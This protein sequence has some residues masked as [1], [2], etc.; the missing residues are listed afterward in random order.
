MSKK[1]AFLPTLNIKN[2]FESSNNDISIDSGVFYLTGRQKQT[3][4]EP[5]KVNNYSSLFEQPKL[6]SGDYF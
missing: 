4:C 6:S 1:Q 3:Y 5:D 2:F